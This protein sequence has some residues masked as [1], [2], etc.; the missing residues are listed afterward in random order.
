MLNKSNVALFFGTVM[1][2]VHLLWAAFV[3]SGFAQAYLDFIFN[4]HFINMAVTV[5]SFDILNAVYLVVFTFLVGLVGG[6][7]LAALWNKL[8]AKKK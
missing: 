7:I 3:A 6:Y 4:L 2:L 1:G 8:V 5:K